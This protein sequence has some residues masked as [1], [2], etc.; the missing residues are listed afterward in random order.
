MPSLQ[1]NLFRFILKHSHLLHFQLKR[2]AVIDFNTSIPRFRRDCEK[3]AGLFGKIPPGIEVSPVMIDGIRAEWIQPSRAAKDKVILYTHGG[4]Y[5]SGSCRD[6]RSIVAR[7]VKGS[8][9]GALLFEYGLAPENPF[10]AAIEDSVAVYGRLLDQG[11]P[12]SRII[13]AGESAGGGLCLAM[14]L[15]LRDRGVPLPAAAV[16]L[17]PWT[18]LK[19]TG[20]SYRTKNKVS[21]APAESWTV[22]SKYYVGDN[23]PCLPWIS[24][25]YGDLHGLPPILIYTGEDDELL[26]DSILF[27]EK[28]AAADVDVTLKVG[29]GMVH[30]YPLLPSF[31]P[32]ARQAMEE[33]CTFIK[34]RIGK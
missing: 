11:I 8:E 31:I 15:A 6:H 18:D 12:A 2:R 14:L 34:T 19:C 20:E 16:A 17:S 33:I 32:E 26:D 5:V 4:G 23:D 28:A 24:P 29:R 30:C 27:A 22:F 9:V 25:L 3:A 13:I 21:L 10:P 1:S 7:V